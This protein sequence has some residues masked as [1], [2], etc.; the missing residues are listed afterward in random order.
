[1]D[2]DNDQEMIHASGKLINIFA[3]SLSEA[4]G[5]DIRA[6][7]KKNGLVTENGTPGRMWDYLNTHICNN[8]EQENML[9]RPTKRGP[10]AMVPII[11][12]DT[13]FIYSIM[14]ESRFKQLKKGKNKRSKAHYVD[15]L[16]RT[17]NLGLHGQERLLFDSAMTV[18]FDDEYVGRIIEGIFRDL[19]I[20]R[21]TV[22][23][24]ALVL[25]SHFNHVLT[26]L[27]CCI[28]NERWEIVCRADWSNYIQSNESSVVDEVADPTSAP[29]NP[30]FGLQF[31]A[32][33]KERIGQKRLAEK[34]RDR[35]QKMK[36][37][38]EKSP[39]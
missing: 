27:Q 33:A 9:G 31:T 24:H 25:F 38:E 10:W 15:A 5:D 39:N 19:R 21:K 28:I 18:Y 1:M 23:R 8:L 14:T 36:V 26:S 29:N 11:E 2:S 4:V 32:K 20:S 7:V 17:F 3:K 30:A 13:G 12:K 22:Q 35:K 37:N 34:K 16:A 6:D